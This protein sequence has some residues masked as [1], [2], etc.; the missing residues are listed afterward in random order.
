MVLDTS[1][2]VAVQLKESGYERL[3][4]RFEAADYILI[5]APTLLEATMVLSARFG[6]ETSAVLTAFL[7]S[8]TVEIV[9]FTDEHYR[10][11]VQAF[12]RYGKGRHRA[13]LNFGDCMA[14]ATAVL[15]GMPLLFVGSDFPQTDIRP[16]L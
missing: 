8:Q 9:P 1:A 7:R 5:G 3:S 4:A 14:Y 11:A 13:A 16:A 6:S 15:A 10:V 12:L 2:V